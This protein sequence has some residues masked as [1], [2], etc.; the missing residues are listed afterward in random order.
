MGSGSGS[1]TRALNATKAIARAV[2]ARGI[3]HHTS[4][5]TTSSFLPD[6]HPPDSHEAALASD[7][8]RAPFLREYASITQAAIHTPDERVIAPADRVVRTALRAHPKR[9]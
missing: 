6:P 7:P 1:A 9:R 2:M 8:Q 4:A 3:A 5:D